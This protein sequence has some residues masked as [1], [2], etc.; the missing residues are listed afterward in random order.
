[1]GERQKMLKS[2]VAASLAA[3]AIAAPVIAQAQPRAAASQERAR[4]Y[5]P[6]TVWVASRIDV[7]DG[8]FENYLDYLSGQWRQI[9]ELGRRERIVVDYHV[10]ATNNP[11]QGEPDIVLIVEYRDY[12]T[13][14]QQEAFQ[15]LVERTLS[16]GP[17]AQDTAS[18][19]RGSMRDLMG[20]VEYQ[21]LVFE[22]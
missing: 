22:D 4:S 8:Q 9:Q 10:L 16:Q 6:G 3:A 14:A 12:Q 17:R 21:E 7:H 5:H 1:M 18:G 20:S 13:T 11:R 19:A 2:F 15:R